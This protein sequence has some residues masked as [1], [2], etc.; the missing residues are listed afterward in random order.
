MMANDPGNPCNSWENFRQ[1]RGLSNRPVYAIGFNPH[2]RGALSRFIQGSKINHVRSARQVPAGAVAL[3][4]G[5]ADMSGNL[6]KNVAVVQLEDG[7]LR[8]VGLGAQFAQPL[9]WV[10]DDQ[11]LYF[12]AKGPSRLESLLAGHTYT[13]VERERARNLLHQIRRAGITKYNTGASGWSRAH[14]SKRIILVPGQVESDASIRFGAP[15]I[16]TNLALVKAVRQ[17]NPDAWIIYKPH[18]DVVA[19]ARKAGNLESSTRNYTDERVT[20]VAITALLDEVDE[21]HTMTSLTGFE[22]LIRHKPVTCYGVPFYSGWGLTNDKVKCSRRHR[23]LTLDELAYSTL[24]QYPLYVSRYSGQYTSPEKILKELKQWHEQPA[25]WR[26]S[27][28]KVARKG[29][30][31]LSGAN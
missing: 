21:I 11:G 7:F 8:S 22:A 29:I 26:D 17:E 27:L 30:N 5:R 14:T 18:P 10:L 25:T 9:S 28:K 12:D 16:S 4:W 31:L 23:Q 19:G 15:D 13:D 1:A 2:W 6:A 24:V 3:I 20:D